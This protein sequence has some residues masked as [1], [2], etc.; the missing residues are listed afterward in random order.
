MN[1]TNQIS[2]IDKTTEGALKQ[3]KKF[4]E[5]IPG[6]HNFRV[7]RYK[8]VSEELGTWGWS[9]YFDTPSME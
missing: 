6:A 4:A 8:L 9:G 2:I 5:G 3:V 7:A 1:E